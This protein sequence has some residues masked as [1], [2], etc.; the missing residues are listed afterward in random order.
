MN[1]S[2]LTPEF[3]GHL[4]TLNAAV[5]ELRK[6]GARI[7]AQALPRAGSSLCQ[8]AI[9]VVGSTL[10]QQILERVDDARTIHPSHIHQSISA[11]G[12]RLYFT[13]APGVYIN[14]KP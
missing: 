8:V 2:V 3:Q 13:L 11:F 6:L 14:S 9:G 10:C 12:V 5:R 7:E 4:Q 1:C